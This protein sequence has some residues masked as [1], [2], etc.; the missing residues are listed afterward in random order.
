MQLAQTSGSQNARIVEKRG[1]L[2]AFQTDLRLPCS[3]EVLESGLGAFKLFVHAHMLRHTSTKRV[4]EKKEPVEAKEHGRHKS[5]KQ[6]ERYAAQT[7]Q[8]REETVDNLW[9]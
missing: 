5:F 4:Y 7:Q 9:S 3:T 1:W 2:A 6:L 8:E